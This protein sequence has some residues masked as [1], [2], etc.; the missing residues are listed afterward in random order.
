MSDQGLKLG[1]R[2][3]GRA[4]GRASGLWAFSLSQFS[5]LPASQFVEVRLM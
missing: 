2:A 5:S 4:H 3:G 1:T